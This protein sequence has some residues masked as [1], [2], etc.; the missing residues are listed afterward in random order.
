VG[1]TVDVLALF[2]FCA[3]AVAFAF[4]LLALGKHDDLR[5]LYLLVVGALALRGSIEILRPRSGGTG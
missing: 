2:L 3:A 5:A 4:G 1:R